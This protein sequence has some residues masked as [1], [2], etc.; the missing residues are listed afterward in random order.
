MKKNNFTFLF[1]ILA[2]LCL[3]ST[4]QAQTF[5]NPY[6]GYGV[7]K[8]NH[9]KSDM[10]YLLD[11][12]SKIDRLYSPRVY[13]GLS[14]T[15]QI[16]EYWNINIQSDV[17]A[18]KFVRQNHGFVGINRTHFWYIRNSVIPTWSIDEKW[19][20]GIGFSF[21]YLSHSDNFI[22]HVDK[23]VEF[24]GILQVTYQI[25]KYFNMHLNYRHGLKAVNIKS[26]IFDP[27]QS[28]NLGLGYRF[29]IKKK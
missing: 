25:N 12:I 15:K 28:L 6:I 9:T 14:I 11:P 22:A 21:D 3:N 7:T 4:L 10:E 8:L 23:R 26:D 5:I 27:L 16:N 29:R 13:L 18:Q 19:R 20:A 17:S 24:G 1:I 2:V